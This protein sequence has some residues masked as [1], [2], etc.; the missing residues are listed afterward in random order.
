[1]AVVS[2]NRLELLQIAEAVARE[3]VIDRSI[4]I[5]AMEEAI[6]KAA[7]SR[8]G[9]E[10]DVHAEIDPRTGALRL[11][12]H[13]LVVD[14]VENDSR[15]IDL[16]SA[17]RHNPAAQVG[18]VISDTLPPFDFGRV[19]AQSAKQVIVQKVREA[20]RERQYDEYKDRIGEVVNG[21][22]KRV[23][24]GNVIVDLGRGEGI[25]RR[26]ESI[27]RE[28]FRPGDR[29]RAYLFDVRHEVRGPQIFLSR[30]HPQFMAK[31][32]GQEVPEIYDGIVEV[33]AVARDPGSRAKIAVISRD[34]SID[35][36]GACVGMRGSRVQAVVGELQGEKIDI[37]PWSQ[38]Q[39]TFIVNALQPAEVVK[40]VLDEEADRIE[41]V[42]PDDQLSLAIGRRGQNVRLA[43]QLTGWDIDILTEAEES[44]RRQKEFVERTDTFMQALDVDETVGQLLAAEGFRSVEEIAYVEPTELANIQGLDEETGAEIQARALDYLNRIEAENDARRIE[45]GV[46]DDL[47]DID[48]ITTPMMVALGENDVKNVEDLAG[49]ATDD[50]VGYTEGRGPEAVRHAGFLDG[51]ELSR[52][53]AEAMIMAARVHAG[54]VEAPPAEEAEEGSEDEHAEGEQADDEAVQDGQ[55]TETEAVPVEEDAAATAE[56]Q[57]T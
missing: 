34:S 13:L 40:V 7:R 37:I 43:S 25:V 50:L 36:V 39:A 23:E 31:L 47:R 54:W 6:A 10:T 55:E 52:T 22:V 20:E 42:V 2:A 19:A 45:L 18:D 9:A 38:D 27:P 26:D 12:R 33:K 46:A 32:F 14:E 16:P 44:E 57:P 28:T 24:Y 5:G 8:Y 56:R 35:P 53:E 41:V 49:C 48:G 4:V 30:S 29:I 11:S 15:E 21:L 3:K 51:F 17:R 1:M